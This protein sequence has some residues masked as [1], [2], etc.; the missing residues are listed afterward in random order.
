VGR[1]QAARKF[2][3]LGRWSA[4]PAVVRFTEV[5][6]RRGTTRCLLAPDSS[7]ELWR[8][9][10]ERLKRIIDRAGERGSW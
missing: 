2:I 8:N 5:A 1:A 10:A 7:E 3:H 9:A 6:R 4:S